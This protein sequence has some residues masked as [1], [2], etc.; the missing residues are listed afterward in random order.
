M[1][2]GGTAVK[3]SRRALVVLSTLTVPALASCGGTDAETTPTG[4]SDGG[5]ADPGAFPATISHL[6]GDTEIVSEPQRIATV[7]W[8]NGDSVLALGLVPVGMP[9]VEWGGNENSSTDWVDATLEELGA[10]WDS[11]AA[12]ATYSEADGINFDEVA[13]LTPDLIVAA[14]RSEEHTS[15]LQ[16]RG[17]L[18]CRLLLEKSTNMETARK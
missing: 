3:L 14:Y 8:V 1:V 5:S 13:A 10:G 4:A 11:D 2:P 9:L 16:S 15:E 7:S 18:V 17:H 12:P 6:Y